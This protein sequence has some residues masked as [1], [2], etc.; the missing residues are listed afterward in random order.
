M[1]AFVPAAKRIQ[2]AILPGELQKLSL[3]HQLANSY[4]ASLKPPPA[5]AAPTI[6]QAQQSIDES[7]RLRRRRGVYA[8]IFAG[9]GAAAPAVGKA[10]LGG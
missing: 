8:N 4:A 10:T 5:P 3:G 7:D 1:T 9:G 6:D 2:N